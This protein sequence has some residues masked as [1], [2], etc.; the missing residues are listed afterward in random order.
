MKPVEC[1]TYSPDLGDR[2]R[3]VIKHAGAWHPIFWFELEEDGSIYLNVR[4]KGERRIKHGT[5]KV[6]NGQV[7]VRYS[8][9]V[10]VT[11][12]EIL[13]KHKLSFHGSGIVNSLAGRAIRAPLRAL[14]A[15]E[16]LCVVLFQHPTKFTKISPSKIQERD[17][18]LNYPVDER[19]PLC[20][21]LYVSPSDKVVPAIQE[22][23]GYQLLL[24]FEYPSGQNLEPITLQLSLSHSAQGPWPPY[25][26]TIFEAVC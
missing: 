1:A 10:E 7:R 20:L 18:C 15:Q 17:V 4:K 24:M 3:I 5:T 25:S 2:I 22:S 26:Y 9:G 12:P 13:K 21:H 19:S 11:N 23:V 6:E 14:E 8:D 16:L